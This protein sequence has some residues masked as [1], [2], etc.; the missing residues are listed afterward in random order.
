MNILWL[1]KLIFESGAQKRSKSESTSRQWKIGGTFKPVVLSQRSGRGYH[2]ICYC[3][4][5]ES[6]LNR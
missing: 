3:Q 6:V 1:L 4:I 5:S 2:L